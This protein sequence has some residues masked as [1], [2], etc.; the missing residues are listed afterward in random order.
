MTRPDGGMWY[1]LKDGRRW[2]RWNFEVGWDVQRLRKLR[3]AVR[4]EYLR[5]AEHGEPL[6][7]CPRTF[8]TSVVDGL[9]TLPSG[10]YGI[11][12]SYALYQRVQCADGTW[13]GGPPSGSAARTLPHALTTG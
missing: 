7:F 8:A 1:R 13:Q 5:V 10:A 9:D 3:S 11:M 2:A 4:A 6:G 12:L